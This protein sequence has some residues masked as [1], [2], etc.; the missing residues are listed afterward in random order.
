[1][2]YSIILLPIRLLTRDD[3]YIPGNAKVSI[4]PVPQY[5]NHPCLVPIESY[6]RAASNERNYKP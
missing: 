3:H 1:M 5:Q 6:T 2:M 4:S